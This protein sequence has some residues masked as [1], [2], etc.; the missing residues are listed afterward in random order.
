[1]ASKGSTGP[2]ENP[3]PQ[4]P[5]PETGA[6]PVTAEG[7][8]DTRVERPSEGEGTKAT[9]MN[10]RAGA[11]GGTD[12]TSGAVADVQASSAWRGATVNRVR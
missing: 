3:C 12:S 5:G 11:D 7:A 9:R 10:C 1:M 6:P 4:R 2:A 8:A